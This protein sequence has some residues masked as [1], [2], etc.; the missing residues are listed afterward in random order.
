MPA[1]AEARFFARLDGEFFEWPDV[2]HQ[3]V[4]HTKLVAEADQKVKTGGVE[5]NALR[6]FV[7]VLRK[8]GR[9][10]A[11]VPRKSTRAVTTNAP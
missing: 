9:D 5:G 11:S 2:V 4:E 7:E 3:D 8:E 6:F 1:V 10:G